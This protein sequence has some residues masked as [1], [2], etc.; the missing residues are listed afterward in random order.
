MNPIAAP[1]DEGQ[2][3]A[4]EIEEEKA[5]R[6]FIHL[7]FPSC[8]DLDLVRLFLHRYRYRPD[9]PP[10]VEDKKQG[11]IE[12]LKEKQLFW[13]A[14]FEEKKLASQLASLATKNVDGITYDDMPQYGQIHVKAESGS[15]LGDNFQSDMFIVTAQLTRTN[16]TVKDDTSISTLSTFVK[17]QPSYSFLRQAADDMCAHHREINMYHN[18][19]RLLREVHEDH[20]MLFYF[21]NVPDVYYSHIEDIIPGETDGSGT[22][23]LLENLKAEGY[24][25]ADKVEGGDYQHCEWLAELLQRLPEIILVDTLES[26]GPLACILH[27]DYCINNILFKYD[28][29]RVKGTNIPVSLKMLDFQTSRIGHPLSD[30]LYFFY[31]STKPETRE[32]DMLVL[33]RYYFNTLTA[34]LRLLSVSLDD[35]TWQDFLSDYKKRSLMWMFMGVMVLSGVLNK[36]SVSNLQ[37]LDAEE[38]L[39]GPKPETNMEPIKGEMGISLE[40]EETMK[41]M[42]VS[43]ELSDSAILS[44]SLIKLMD[45]VKALNCC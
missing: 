31:T 6:R 28:S 5:L 38:K 1:E 12:N 11:E 16:N 32:E 8:T 39:K 29:I 3:T 23:I 40:M 4:R 25:M 9:P 22:C 45:E 27:G 35:Y 7:Q 30:V 42:M 18:F 2:A 24:R 20:P 43:Y 19:F 36:K 33:L 41:N 34:D 44:E 14:L 17:V 13:A 21:L 15:T 10:R 37:D 26:S